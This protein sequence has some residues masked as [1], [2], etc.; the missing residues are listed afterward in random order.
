M[1]GGPI[2]WGVRRAEESDDEVG[3]ASM[4]KVSSFHGVK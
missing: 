2:G 1:E 3:P 4:E